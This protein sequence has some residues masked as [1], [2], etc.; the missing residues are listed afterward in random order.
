MLAS[1]T[2][3]IAREIKLWNLEISRSVLESTQ[4]QCC[5]LS[6]RSKDLFMYLRIWVWI[7]SLKEPDIAL[8]FYRSGVVPR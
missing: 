2:G 8:C 1:Y 3:I 7:Y 6:A 4:S 5:M